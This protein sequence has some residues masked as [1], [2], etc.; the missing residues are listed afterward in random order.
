MQFLNHFLFNETFMLWKSMEEI[1]EKDHTR[2]TKISLMFDLSLVPFG[3]R[4]IYLQHN[5]SSTEV[6]RKS[7]TIF[8]GSR[9]VPL[10]ADRLSTLS[11]SAAE[12]STNA[13]PW[14]FAVLNPFI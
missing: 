12:G 14:L 5:L 1:D 3:S 9:L 4:Y 11:S 6:S 7:A 10:R 2:Y 13:C 8:T